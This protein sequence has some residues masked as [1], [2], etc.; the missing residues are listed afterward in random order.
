M[1]FKS[2][3]ISYAKVNPLGQLVMGLEDGTILNAGN[4]IGCQGKIGSTGP[5]GPIGPI[6]NKGYG[7]KQLTTT[8][9]GQLQY[10]LEN[11]NRIYNAGLLPAITGPTGKSGNSMINFRCENNILYIDT[12]DDKHFIAGRLDGPTGPP[13][14]MGLQGSQG[15]VGKPF[16]ISNIFTTNNSLIMMDDNGQAYNC[17]YI[18]ITG[19]TGPM[20]YWDN[21]FIDKHGQLL[22]FYK[23]QFIN[24]GYILG[25]TGHTGT[26]GIKGDTGPRGRP[27][28][29]L[30][31][32][33]VN[34]SEQGELIIIDESSKIYNVGNV[35]ITGPT[36]STLCVNSIDII[37]GNKLQFTFN[38]NQVCTS[39]K[40]LNTVQGPTGP[41]FKIS[42]II[43][44]DDNR[45]IFVDDNKKSYLTKGQLCVPTLKDF[46]DIKTELEIIKQ[47][48]ANL[49]NLI[50]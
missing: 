18:G 28:P 41:R 17:G 46:Q 2:T 45:F 42:E 44:S 12:D 7:L 8:N 27:G 25:P 35:C 19:P 11:D 6:G 13:G 49:K 10:I 24:A 3:P 29:M 32:K 1:N 9:D 26:I 50:K 36:G 31:F 16:T 47:E 34:L 21:A 37:T 39:T 23:D 38:D 15:P 14:I 22:L 30:K 20:C 48:L 40:C 5:P 33:D 43:L 4:V